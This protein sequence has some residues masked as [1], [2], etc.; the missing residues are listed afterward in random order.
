MSKFKENGE[1][2]VSKILPS[3]VRDRGWDY[4]LE[5]HSFFPHWHKLVNEET[6]AHAK[7]IKIVKNILWVE[8]ENSAWLQQFQF[9]KMVMLESINSFLQ[10]AQLEDIRF[11]LPQESEKK[12]VKQRAVRF[13]SPPKNELE[14]F[15]EQAGCIKD[16]EARKALIRFW[17]LSKACKRD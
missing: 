1:K 15:E 2:A 9:Q 13:V 14:S 11:T 10:K 6:A 7:P 8:V 17:Y 5:L 12:E 3:L 16:D 4:Q